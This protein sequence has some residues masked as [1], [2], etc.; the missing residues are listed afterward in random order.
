MRLVAKTTLVFADT[1]CRP[2]LH[3]APH[4]H[5]HTHTRA[6]AQ[7]TC[8]DTTPHNN[9][10]HTGCATLVTLLRLGR[11]RTRSLRWTRRRWWRAHG[12]ALGRGWA[13][14]RRHHGADPGHQ[15]RESGCK[16][17]GAKEAGQFG[18]RCGWCVGQA[19]HTHT[20]D[21][22]CAFEQNRQNA[23][24]ESQK[25]AHPMHAHLQLTWPSCR[26]G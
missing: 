17:V 2:V 20:R 3:H 8:Y 26:G 19:A 12:A 25:R 22:R 18:C 21:V 24:I 1:L 23:H 7:R 16:L 14:G 11:W 15:L 10:A 13:R 9:A 5:T 6:R 4:A